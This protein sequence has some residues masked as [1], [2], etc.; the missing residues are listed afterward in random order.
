VEKRISSRMLVRMGFWGGHVIKRMPVLAIAMALRANDEV[1]DF[2]FALPVALVRTSRFALVRVA[3]GAVTGVQIILMR[4]PV[5][6]F[7]PDHPSA[8]V[9]TGII[10]PRAKA[11]GIPSPG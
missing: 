2:F 1:K 11:S 7:M 9:R 6:T 8:S 4:I 3:H 5:S 10:E